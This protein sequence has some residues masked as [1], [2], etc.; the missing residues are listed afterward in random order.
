MFGYNARHAGRVNAVKDNDARDRD[1]GF[2]NA[3][4]VADY[5]R[6]LAQRAGEVLDQGDFALVLG[7]DCSILLG[8]MLALNRRGRH[9]LLFLDGH[10]DF[11]DQ[12]TNIYG[13]PH[14]PSSRWSR[15]EGR[16]S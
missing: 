4:S 1:K 10:M 3:Q 16:P 8:A 2:L 13:G 11:Y 7:G 5:S 9:G 12:E 15:A 14:L 6:R